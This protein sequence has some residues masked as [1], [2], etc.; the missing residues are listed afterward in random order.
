MEIFSISLLNWFIFIY[1]LFCVLAILRP[2]TVKCAF[3]FFPNKHDDNIPNKLDQDNRQNRLAVS[4]GPCKWI[5]NE[6]CPSS[7]IKFYLYTR[8]NQQDRQLIHVDE[9]WD[10][11]NLSDS[12][13][14]AGDPTKIILH[15]YNSDMF[16]TPLIQMKGG[17]VAKG[18]LWTAR[19]AAFFFFHLVRFWCEFD[20]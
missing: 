3:P 12:N 13:F 17:M 15:G 19:R 16:L 20:V 2:S 10:K 5:F 4:I 18:F 8:K 11:S 14:N 1:L 9:T 6:K 7:D